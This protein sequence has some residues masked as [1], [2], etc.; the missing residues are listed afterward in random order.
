MNSRTFKILGAISILI[1]GILGY[2][3]FMSPL[4]NKLRA[5]QPEMLYLLALLLALS[6]FNGFMWFKV[7]KKLSR[8]FKIK[9]NITLSL[10][11]VTCSIT[12]YKY[13][14]YIL[15]RSLLGTLQLISGIATFVILILGITFLQLKYGFYYIQPIH[16][17]VA[18]IVIAAY[19]VNMCLK[20][21][22]FTVILDCY[23]KYYYF[24]TARIYLLTCL[25]P[26]IVSAYYILGYPCYKFFGINLMTNL[27]FNGLT[28]MNALIIP[29]IMGYYGKKCGEAIIYKMIMTHGVDE[30]DEFGVQL[31]YNSY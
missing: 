7:L 28:I 2:S 20:H 8:V 1:I 6:L 29:C 16:L 10:L 4:L 27:F 24:S 5:E 17:L 25:S 14:K 18:M 30:V 22:A 26:G 9:N 11:P 31:E 13:F 3:I 15:K 19:N 12:I 23:N 21:I